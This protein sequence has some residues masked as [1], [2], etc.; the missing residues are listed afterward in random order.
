M[1]DASAQLEFERAA[2]LRDRLKAMAHIQARQGINTSAVDDADVV[3]SALRGRSGLRP[4]VLLPQRAELRESGLLPC[5]T[6]D[7]QP[8]EILA[9]FLAQFYAERPPAPLLLLAEPV[10]EQALLVEAL[11]VSAGRRVRLLVPQRGDRRQLVETA[12]TNARAG[13]GTAARRHREPGGAARAAGDRF[14]L[15]DTPARIEVYDNSHIQGTNA[16][17]AFIVAGPEG[18]DKRTTVRLTSR[19]A[20]LRRA[21]I[22]A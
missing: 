16:I 21:T 7:A 14:E 11:T 5:H 15:P 4:G 8:G 9:A 20:S 13:A 2:V 17:G 22:S 1:R 3:A 10:A 19:P 12:L 6:K 18:F